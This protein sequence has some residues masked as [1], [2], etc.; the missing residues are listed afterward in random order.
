MPADIT[1]SPEGHDQAM[2]DKVDA[3]AAAALAAA[4]GAPPVV[5]PVAPVKPE[6]VPDKFWN[7]EKGE[8][9]IAGMAKS[10]TE[11]EKAKG[12]APTTETPPE[13][14]PP[15][16]PPADQN[17]DAAKAAVGADAF[18]A[19]S[20]E[21]AE[22]GAL[23]EDSYKALEAKGIPKA[24][25]DQY[26]QGQVALASSAEAQGF[27]LVGG[28]DKYSTMLQ[29][30]ATS[31]TASEIDAFDKAVLSDNAA[32]RAQAI[33]GLKARYEGAYGGD[34]SGMVNGNAPS[35]AK[36]YASE[37]EMTRDMKD[38]RYAKDPAYRK[39]VEQRLEAT[40]AF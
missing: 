17:A 25:V 35:F 6:G 39:Q 12:A 3:S 19:F 29:W 4:G 33:L 21:F 5:A 8:V 31:M 27:S 18:E 7:A 20:A 11:L 30:A 2:I 36:G 37:A 23:S 24:L 16:T 15:A 40:T 26:I 13:A 9:D 1:P 28:E 32:A 34:Q 14:T 38:P 22:K 10:Y